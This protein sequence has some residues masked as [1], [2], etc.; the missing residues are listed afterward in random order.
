[1]PIAAKILLKSIM[2]TITQVQN[3]KRYRIFAQ[4]MPKLEKSAIKV[5]SN[6]L[7]HQRLKS[8]YFEFFFKWSSSNR[9][10]EPCKVKKKFKNVYFSPDVIVQ[11]LVNIFFFIYNPLCIQVLPFTPCSKLPS[12]RLCLFL[13]SPL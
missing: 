1:M 10:Q 8:M 13:V 11:T 7:P 5:K 3:F 6:C 12:F 2:V 4:S 9:R